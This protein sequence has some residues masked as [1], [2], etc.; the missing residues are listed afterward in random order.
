MFC[1]FL[2]AF[3]CYSLRKKR[4]QS[5]YITT[6]SLCACSSSTGADK[7]VG[8]TE[9]LDDMAHEAGPVKGSSRGS[10]VSMMA[11][12]SYVL[13]SGRTLYASASFP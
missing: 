13:T 2:V 10:P 6:D 9:R 8:P 1:G 5:F 12:P 11:T 7:D 4:K 3:A